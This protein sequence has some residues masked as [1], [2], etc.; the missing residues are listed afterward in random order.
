MAQT[1][2]AGNIAAIIAAAT[3]AAQGAGAQGGASTQG[4]A[5]TTMGAPAPESGVTIEVAERRQSSKEAASGDAGPIEVDSIVTIGGDDWAITTSTSDVM[6]LNKVNKEA[7]AEEEVS[8]EE[9][10]PLAALLALIGQKKLTGVDEI[11][12]LESLLEAVTQKKP[13]EEKNLGE[14]IEK[15]FGDNPEF[16]K[17][18]RK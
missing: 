2:P 1:Q 12:P 7:V 4:G 16:I 13:A 5:G 11:D 6:V 10:D 17:A 9:V 14:L 3:R 8:E 15:I 18:S